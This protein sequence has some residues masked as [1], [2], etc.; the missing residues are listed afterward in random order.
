MYAT[1]LTLVQILVVSIHAYRGFGMVAG[2][3]QISDPPFILKT[4]YMDPP[5]CIN[6]SFDVPMPTVNCYFVRANSTL[7][8][9]GLLWQSPTGP[10]S[11]PWPANLELFVIQ[12]LRTGYVIDV[13][14]FGQGQTN[15]KINLTHSPLESK[16]LPGLTIEVFYEVP[17]IWKLGGGRKV[18][19]GFQLEFPVY[20]NAT[21]TVPHFG[22]VVLPRNVGNA[23]AF[24]SPRTRLSHHLLSK[25]VTQGSNGNL[26]AAVRIF[27]G[28]F[29][30]SL[31]HWNF[32]SDVSFEIS[33]SK[34][35]FTFTYKNKLPLFIKSL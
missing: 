11:R 19:F 30:V 34:E 29:S 25:V 24:T 4:L 31:Y 17:V 28:F 20:L 1:Q 32:Y 33:G 14:A 3:E 23:T 8:N 18:N 15:L 21:V 2:N 13:G 12:S 16:I 9:P 22:A 7:V 27:A 5:D 10:A 26:T 6:A 35:G